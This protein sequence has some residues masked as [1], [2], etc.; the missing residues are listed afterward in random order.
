MLGAFALG[1]FMVMGWTALVSEAVDL[2]DRVR[3]ARCDWVETLV[4]SV[5]GHELSIAAAPG[6]TF[7]TGSRWISGEEVTGYR[8]PPAQFGFCLDR[9]PAGPVSARSLTLTQDAARAAIE[10]AGLPAV[11]GPLLEIGEAALFMPDAPEADGQSNEMT[12]FFRNV[13][14]GWPRMVTRGVTQD[15]FRVG[16]VCR[17]VSGGGW[18]CDVSVE[19]TRSALSYRF[20]QLPFETAAFDAAPVPAPFLEV[21]RGMRR[22]GQVLEA[23]ALALR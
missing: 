12:V 16:A 2:T 3:R 10:Q 14:F 19:D 18:L 7:Y 9:R 4:I 11:A 15:G 20:E 5:S 6:V 21:A 17:D 8:R 13:D 1:I 23:D 22:L